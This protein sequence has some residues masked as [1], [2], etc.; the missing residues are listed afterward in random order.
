MRNILILPIFDRNIA[1]ITFSLISIFS[2]MNVTK[3]NAKELVFLN[4]NKRIPILM[5]VK[6]DI[7]GQ[8]INYAGNDNQDNFKKEDDKTTIKILVLNDG[9]D[10]RIPLEN[11]RIILDG[12]MCGETNEKGEFEKLELIGKHIMRVEKK[13]FSPNIK[14]IDLTKYS[15]CYEVVLKRHELSFFK[16]GEDIRRNQKIFID[17]ARGY[18][19]SK[20]IGFVLCFSGFITFGVIILYK[21]KGIIRETIVFD[22][23]INNYNYTDGKLQMV[24]VNIKLLSNRKGLSYIYI[25]KSCFKGLKKIVFKVLKEEHQDMDWL[26]KREKEIH[27]TL[28]N[29]WTNKSHKYMARYLGSGFLARNNK[30]KVIVFE[31]IKGISLNKIISTKKYRF[32]QAIEMGIG[33]C[34]TVM[35]VHDTGYCHFDLKP[36]HF[37]YTGQNR[38]T[39]IDIATAIRI[40]EHVK[41]IFDSQR[42]TSP[43]QRKRGIAIDQRTD[44][45]SLGVIFHEL[46]SNSK[47]YNFDSMKINSLQIVIRKMTDKDRE[48]RYQYISEI[49]KDL[50]AFLKDYK[51]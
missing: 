13:G 42:Y 32:R 34:E 17:E 49:K 22:D 21:N 1:F 30:Q 36:E 45:Y 8:K 28:G 7:K 20:I 19:I 18:Y 26:F 33:L 11:T 12:F 9:V 29:K 39:L 40:G 37:I 14:D 16:K 27:V 38:F 2:L 23:A 35:A 24:R 51:K 50:E 31:Y 47:F 25:G 4:S 46:F 44:I 15:G 43:E 10:K 41:T 48:V 5:Y 3:I 6:S